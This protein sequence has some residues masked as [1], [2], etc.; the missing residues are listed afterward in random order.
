MNSPYQNLRVERPAEGVQVVQFHRPHALN[1]LD[2]E[3]LNELNDCVGA[4]ETEGKVR[5]IIFTGGGDGTFISGGDISEMSN[6]GPQEASS[7][8]R[9]GQRVLQRLVESDI[10]TIAAIN[11][12]ALG[13]GLEFALAC[14]IRLAS[15]TASVG[16]PEVTLGA[17]CGFGGTQRLPRIIGVS[18]AAEM[19]L[20]GKRVAAAE[21]LSWGIVSNVVAGPELLPAAVQ[22]ARDILSC[23]PMAVRVTKRL[24]HQGLQTDI[25]SGLALEQYAFAFIFSSDSQ[26]EGMR[27][28]L[29][30]R[31]PR[32]E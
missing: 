1:A 11:G 22:L 17:V 6:M 7:Y 10:V 23:A 9:L 26:K 14:D 32:F 16:L 3:T 18:K 19:L 15:E 30:K 5:V 29:E 8:S 28:F 27:A 13:G 31:P 12:H 20:T 4:A 24:M 21:A 2:T 25:Y